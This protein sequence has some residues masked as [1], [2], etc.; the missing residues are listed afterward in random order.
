MVRE[1]RTPCLGLW[2]ASLLVEGTSCR[3]SWGSEGPPQGI[4]IPALVVLSAFTIFPA[5][6]VFPLIGRCPG[7]ALSLKRGAGGPGSEQ[8]G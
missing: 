1:P 5:P 3:M 6:G 7:H 2:G 4:P 8:P